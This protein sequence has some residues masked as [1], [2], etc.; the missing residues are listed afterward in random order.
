MTRPARVSAPARSRGCRK[1][2]LGCERV[3][4]DADRGR[5]QPTRRLE[6]TSYLAAFPS[7]LPS[8]RT[9]ARPAAAH[10]E[11]T[12]TNRGPSV[13]MREPVKNAEVSGT[14]PQ[15]RERLAPPGRGVELVAI[16]V[17][18]FGAGRIAKAPVTMMR[19]PGLPLPAGSM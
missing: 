9:L 1:K 5:R 15:A 13:F 18:G 17:V 7:R 10:C 8:L 19:V 11:L 2:N 3:T 6:K 4:T 14:R 12:T 16:A